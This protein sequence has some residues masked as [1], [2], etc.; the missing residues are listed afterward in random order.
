MF[1]LLAVLYPCF[2]TAQPLQNLP[3]PLNDSDYFPVEQAEA[4]LGQLLF[5][6]RILSGNE[7]I[8]CATCHH[9]DFGTSDG[10]ALSF[11][12]GGV[13]LGPAR[14]LDP[15][16]MPE[17]RIPR[18]SPALFNL[19]SREVVRLFHD[20]RLE[21]DPAQPNGIRTPMGGDMAEGFASL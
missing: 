20:G 10:L 21:F 15:S 16:N 2:A 4:E 14:R 13:G 1:G 19:G 6:D 3:V 9:P 7:T 17:K 8:A 18:N 5:Y 11:G 12:D